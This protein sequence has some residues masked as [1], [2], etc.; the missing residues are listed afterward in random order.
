MKKFISGFLLLFTVAAFAQNYDQS[1]WHIPAKDIDPNNYFGI[2]VGNGMVGIVS[3]PQPMRVQD[4]VLNGVYDNYQRGRVS[5]ILKT[6]NHVNFDLDINRRRVGGDMVSN[7][8]QV[9]D[10]KKAILTTTFDIEDLA[11]VEHQ[12]MSLRQL[13]FTAMVIMKITAKKDIL[14]TPISVMEAPDHL[15]EVNQ[16]Y[17]QIDRPHV[18]FPLM[19]SVGKSPSG[20]STVAASSTFIFPEEHGHEPK[21]IHEDWDFNRHWAKFDKELKA[22]ETYTFALVGSTLASEHFADPH[23]EAER[24]TIYARLEG[25]DR[26]IERHVAAWDEL[27]ESDIVIEGDLQS[28]KDVRSALYHLYSFARAGTA[29]SLSPMGLSGLGYN[30]HVFWDTELWMYPPLLMLQPDIAKSLL[31]YRFQR[32]EAAKQNAFAHGYKG[33]QFP[34][35]S[36]DD[37]SE[38]TPVWALTGP[39]EHHITG[40]VG[41]A[42][43]KYYQVTGDKEWLRDRGW[44]VLKE[45][46]T[47]WASRVERNGP[48]QYDIKNVIGANEWEENI[49]NNAFTNAIAKLTLGYATEAAQILGETA[50]PDWA[51][52]AANIPV[53]K[54]D[55]GTTRENATYV[56]VMIKQADVNLLSYPLQFYSDKK[57]IEKDLKFYET[58]MSPN[59]PAMGF[60]VLATIYARLGDANKAFDVWTNSFRPNGV[61]P[62]GVL[63]ETRGGTNPY[64]ATGAGG[65][66]QTVLGG[67][68][69]LDITDAGIVK[70]KQNL[71]KGWKSLEIKGFYK[72]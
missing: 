65:M 8:Q 6:F 42:F 62:F 68:G 26:L 55:D 45:V 36:A 4:V 54:F 44:P 66:L 64:F 69:G 5:N 39:F 16:F 32:L 52:V 20:S 41:W 61:P 51:N 48:G 70:G 24:L 14:I 10:M 47:F 67:F 56:D 57:Q 17:A 1:P 35:E 59:G 21:V 13:P 71:P 28:Q 27:W 22:G 11:S 37:G 34:W 30:G 53:L 3:S 18:S 58:K 2:T 50:D 7:Y 23:N 33:A 49:D 19:T 15:T 25:M 9:L 43:W 38:D 12:M 46:A 31:E 29:Y 63:S 72:K 60:C 40:C